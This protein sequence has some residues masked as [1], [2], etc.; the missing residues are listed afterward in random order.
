MTPLFDILAGP[1]PAP[2][3]VSVPAMVAAGSAGLFILL[4][5]GRKIVAVVQAHGTHEAATHYA[6]IIALAKRLGADSW[7][8]KRWK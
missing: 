2:I 6:D 3:Q 1:R 7:E 8:W 4:Y 5:V